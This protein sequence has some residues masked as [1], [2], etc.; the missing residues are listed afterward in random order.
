MNDE[1]NKILLAY[2]A[3]LKIRYQHISQI[4]QE[5]LIAQQYDLHMARRALEQL[6][7]SAKKEVAGEIF[8]TL[9]SYFRKYQ[10]SG[11]WYMQMNDALDVLH[12]KYLTEER[13]EEG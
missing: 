6:I 5:D 8:D 13:G 11:S 12:K 4:T 3:E 10:D 9:N 2:K 1:I 7:T